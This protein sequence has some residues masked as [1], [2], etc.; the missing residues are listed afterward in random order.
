[1]DLANDLGNLAQRSLSMIFKNCDGVMP[2]PGDN[3]EADNA[4]LSALDGLL[5]KVRDHM[6]VQAFN[7]ALE[8]I[9]KVVSDANGYFAGEEPWALKKT[10]PERMGTVLYTTAEIIRQI[11]IITQ[12][13]MPDSASKLI[14][15][16]KVPASERGFDKL[17][18]DHR[19]ASG[20]KMEKPEGVF[21][22][23]V[24]ENE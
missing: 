2:T 12:P 8:T 20:T 21:P 13:I 18:A 17:G 6:D 4:I 24:A 19:L 10:D 22:R 14:D 1:S 3:T 11:G 7:K 15:L 9:W 5:P 16:L 23:Y